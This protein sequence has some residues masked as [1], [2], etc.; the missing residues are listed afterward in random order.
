MWRSDPSPASPLEFVYAFDRP[1]TIHTVQLHQNPDWP[2]K[3]VQV[4]VSAD[5]RTY[6]SLVTR[7]L[8]ER[9]EPNANFAFTIDT[10]LS[11]GAR[12][13]KLCL[14]S[15]YKSRYWGLGEIEA[16]GSGAVMLPDDD[17]YFVNADIHDL[18]PGTTC[19]YRLVATNSLGTTLGNDWAFTLPAT[20]R[21][22]VE[23]G[24]FMRPTRSSA[25]VEGR[26][27]PLGLPS[28]FYFEY[29]RD[30]RYGFRSPIA[31]AGLEI[32]PRSVFAT[33]A[34]LESSATYHYRLVGVN[35]S[36]T[37]L[38]SDATFRTR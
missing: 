11:A 24:R 9:G 14:H 17:L 25:S 4:M 33:L 7:V 3:D 38:G 8:P 6:S 36:G 27:N 30:S 1:V 23:T 10:G 21:P 32:T 35:G 31:Y 22:H 28:Y 15:G 34:D 13:L 18:T 2:A 16:F 29:G 20:N 5:G 12:F 37:S 19:H 26:L